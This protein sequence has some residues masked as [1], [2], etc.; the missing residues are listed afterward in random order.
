MKKYIP[1]LNGTSFLG[2]ATHEGQ[3][4]PT[5]ED[6]V[7]ASDVE[8]EI[9]KAMYDGFRNGYEAS[10]MVHSGHPPQEFKP[11]EKLEHCRRD[12]PLNGHEWMLVE[13]IDALVDR[14][15]ALWEMRKG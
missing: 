11:L 12:Y 9:R 8:A 4:G 3:W 7:L 5:F 6:Y 2:M 10:S 15:N 1:L 13:Q 14:V